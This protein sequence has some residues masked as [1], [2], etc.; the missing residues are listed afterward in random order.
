MNQVHIHLLLN[1]MPVIG[2]FFAL[3]ILIY[4]LRKR[5]YHT[6]KAAYFLMIIC[7]ITAGI[8]FFTGEGAEEVVE[9]I[10][11]ISERAIEE[12]EDAGKLAWFSMILVG[13][14]AVGALVLMK[15][16]SHL[17]KS[18]A[19]IMILVMVMSLTI[20]AYAA[21][22]GGKIRHTEIDNT[23]GSIIND[24]NAIDDLDDAND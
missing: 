10:A 22:L 20:T 1:H 13:I 16:K 17:Y 8:T 12:H 9:N 23:N 15:K 7:T 3:L 5:S 21:N 4:G 24:K 2:G 14:G 18:Y 19:I 6:Q 11:G